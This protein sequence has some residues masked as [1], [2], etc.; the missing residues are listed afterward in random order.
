MS[1]EIVHEIDQARVG[2]EF[3]PFLLPLLVLVLSCS[4][5]PGGL[6]AVKTPDE[7]AAIAAHLWQTRLA[8]IFGVT[9][10]DRAYE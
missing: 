2:K 10:L 7:A 9:V 3:Y 1:Y 4:P 5:E 6:V 8:P